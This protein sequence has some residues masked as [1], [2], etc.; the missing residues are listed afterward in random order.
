MAMLIYFLRHGDASSD[1]SMD[2]GARPLTGLG[3]RQA[4]LVG[5]FLQQ[6]NTHVDI[7]LSSPLKRAQQTAGIVQPGISPV[8]HVALDLLLNGTDYRKLFSHLESLGVSSVMLVGHIPHLSDTAALLAGRESE[9]FIEMKKCSLA[10]IKS[11][12]PLSAGSGRLMQLMHV[13]AIEKLIKE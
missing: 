5:K 1:S 4:T 11:A 9:D 2:D 8:K 6:S 3:I 10:V 7:I 13:S 12:S